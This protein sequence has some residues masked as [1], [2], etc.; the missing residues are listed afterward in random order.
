MAL[1]ILLIPA[2][3]ADPEHLFSGVKIIILDYRN[4]LSIYI[5]KALE[6]LKSWLKI[7]AFKE[8]DDVN[9]GQE[10]GHIDNIRQEGAI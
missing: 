5:I 8:E 9:K 7:K 2:M 1:N 4:R 6:Y 10:E 3:S